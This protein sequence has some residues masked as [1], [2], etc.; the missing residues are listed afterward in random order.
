MAYHVIFS[1]PDAVICRGPGE[2]PRHTYNAFDEAKAA[3]IDDLEYWKERLEAN[4]ERLRSA[5]RIEDLEP[6]V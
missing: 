1:V 3:A 2:D 6:P 5:K 4:L